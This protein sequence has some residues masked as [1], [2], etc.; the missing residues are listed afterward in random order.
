MK[1]IYISFLCVLLLAIPS[2]LSYSHV[3]AYSDDYKVDKGIVY[4]NNQ[5]VQLKGVSWFGFESKFSY[6]PGGLDKRDYKEMIAQMKQLGFNAVR[7]P[8]CPGTLRMNTVNGISYNNNINSD[9]KYLKSIE[10][11]D[12]VVSEL[13]AQQMYILLD[14]HRIDCQTIP[15]LWYD[16][17]YSE[18]QWIEDLRFMA[19]RYKNLEYFMGIDIKNEP[20]GKATWGTGNLQTDW[21]IAAENASQQILSVN[22]NILIF[23]QGIQSNP[24]CSTN[25]GYWWG[26]NFEP[27]NCAPLSIPKEKL[28][29]SPHVYGPDV[30][31][32]P[33]FMDSSFPQNM[34]AI[35]QSHFGYLVD[36]G[37]TVIPGEW[38]GKY[39]NGGD[40][41]DVSFQDSITD[42][43][44]QKNI[45][46]S[47]YWDWNPDSGDTGGILQ[48]DWQT[49]W[50][51]KLA[52]LQN[53]YNNCK[54]NSSK[55]FSSLTIQP[56]PT[57]TP[58]G[59]GSRVEI[60]AAG[61]P[62]N[63]T[64]P[65]IDLIIEGKKVATFQSINGDINTRKLNSYTYIHN[66]NI[67]KDAV[68]EIR[69]TNDGAANGQDRNILLDKIIVDGT[70]LETEA[71][72][73]YS[74]GLWNT[75]NG[76]QAGYKT[77]ELLA[78]NG[79][80]RYS[81]NTNAPA[82]S[83]AKP[84]PNISQFMVQ[85]YNNP[86]LS[87]TPVTTLMQDDISQ[88]WENS[89][90]INELPSDNFSLRATKIIQTDQAIYRFAAAADDAIRVI[91][92]GETIID[93][94]SQVKADPQ[95]IDIALASGQHD[96]WIEYKDVSAEAFLIFEY[97]E[98]Q[99]Q[100][101]QP[102]S[103]STPIEQ[104]TVLNETKTFKAEYFPNHSLQGKPAL[105]KD[106][107]DISFDWQQDSP[108]QQIPSDNFSV[109][110]TK[111]QY[112]DQGTYTFATTTD[113]GV[114][115][116]LDDKLI[117][118]Q[119]HDNDSDSYHAT[120]EITKGLHQ[121]VMEYYDN[122]GKATAKLTIDKQLDSVQA[123]STIRIY[124]AG[125][126]LDKVYP[127]FALLLNGQRVAT[128]DDIRGN[129][130]TREFEIREYR[131][132]QQL[133]NPDIRIEFLNDALSAS[134][135]RNLMIDRIVV[136]KKTLQTES[137]TVY[138]IG[139][140]DSSAGCNGGYKQSEWLQCPGLLKY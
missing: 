135:D 80:V 110:W 28:V 57:V 20:H 105:V 92:D 91:I 85:Y 112:F 113:D 29:L 73:V 45:C 21:D 58:A 66:G 97:Q 136:N 16:D 124:V 24:T 10:V 68:V 30:Y 116:Y 34:P 31:M 123:G 19:S 59:V 25:D 70:T 38:G 98:V 125:T 89:S 122:S 78:C 67:S 27:I 55:A 126:P 94:W 39:G 37:Y 63:N 43:F 17:S 109:R 23:V 95:I 100:N 64:Y 119:W 130:A 56:S 1:K 93:T 47:F 90:A 40:P 11:L 81:L 60:I 62:A 102:A 133:D 76:C 32:Q 115:L 41:K 88:D 2:Y 65:S 129:P 9:L 5:P 82:N 101:P 79:F 139:S 121:I 140:W 117:I 4:H 36:K 86:E 138:S 18:G 48:D 103:S 15:E 131:I 54:Q 8:L 42:Y 3:M 96:L 84:S 69:Y 51:N 14:H 12:K 61:S 7:L 120:H 74:E 114:K 134:E 33:Y 75:T 6:M 108:D 53:Y 111:N 77:S 83:T 71:D 35:W 128:F 46:N 13:N 132:P 137:P 49:P 127:R 50:S 52:M 118:N 107:K 72:N 26:A 99:T 106:H 22:S 87:G 104:T 44:V